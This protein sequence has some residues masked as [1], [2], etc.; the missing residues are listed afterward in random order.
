MNKT[1]PYHSQAFLIYLKNIA[2]Y[3]GYAVTETISYDNL[4]GSLTFCFVNRKREFNS[5][6]QEV[7]RRTYKRPIW[8]IR[9]LNKHGINSKAE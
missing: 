6:P 2:R 7:L 9:Y 8:L 4:D 1:N 5:S 3:C